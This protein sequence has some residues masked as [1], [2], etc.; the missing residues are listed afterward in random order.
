MNMQIYTLIYAHRIKG[1]FRGSCWPATGLSIEYHASIKAKR[2]FWNGIK[3]IKFTSSKRTKFQLKLKICIKMHSSIVFIVL[4]SIA[5]VASA[6]PYSDYYDHQMP[7]AMRLRRSLP[8]NEPTLYEYMDE[9]PVQR[10]RRQTVFGGVTPGNPGT[11]GT[12]GARGNVFN[13]NGHSLDAHG[14]VSRTFKP[15]GPVNIGGGLDYQG[16][17]GGVSANVDHTR[18]IGTNV[19]V[20]GNANIWRS[21]DGRS[22]LDGT[23]SYN[24]QFGPYGGRPQYGAG[25]NFKHNF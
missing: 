11:T 8:E 21:R 12:I 18:H 25:L 6:Y 19:G 20:N 24:Q 4:A 16:P 7:F 3:Q 9:V 10:V 23:A 1:I 5:A 2:A 14:Q 17:R 22:S 15:T 13:N